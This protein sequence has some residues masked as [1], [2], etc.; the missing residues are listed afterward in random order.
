VKN[1]I[2][3][4]AFLCLFQY[5]YRCAQTQSIG[6]PPDWNWVQPIGGNSG[7][8]HG[9]RIVGDAQGNFFIA[10]DFSGSTLFGNTNLT[11]QGQIN[12]FVAKCNP[13]GDFWWSRSH[14]LACHHLCI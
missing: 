9:Q 8:D 4:G 3:F 1:P 13:T 14:P 2:L 11:T 12:G 6:N 5:N 7:P 10:G